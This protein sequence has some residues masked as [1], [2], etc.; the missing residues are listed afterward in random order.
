MT[1]LIFALLLIC[2]SSAQATFFKPPQPDKYEGDKPYTP[3]RLEWLTAYNQ[4]ECGVWLNGIPTVSWGLFNINGTKDTITVKVLFTDE[5]VR[6]EAQKAAETCE[7]NILATTKD[8][9]WTWIKT[10]LDVGN[11]DVS[12]NPSGFKITSIEKGSI[13]EKLGLNTGDVIKII[14]GKPINN[15]NDTG[16]LANL[17]KTADKI[18]IELLREGSTRKL[19]YILKQ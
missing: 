19:T 15:I 5:K 18:E 12:K 2:S 6:I 8:R 17:F 3:T 4:N 1:K 7:R 9:G 14:N 16:E 11:K 13:F 10:A